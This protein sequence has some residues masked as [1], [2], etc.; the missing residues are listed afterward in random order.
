MKYGTRQVF[1]GYDA[2]LTSLIISKS[3]VNSLHIF[4]HRIDD[5]YIKSILKQDA[6][7]NWYRKVLISKSFVSTGSFLYLLHK[8]IKQFGYLVRL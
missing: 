4:Q 6:L 2:M 1:V 8:L 3:S 7:Y 5:F